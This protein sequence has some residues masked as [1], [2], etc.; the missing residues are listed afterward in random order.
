MATFFATKEELIQLVRWYRE[1]QLENKIYW[2]E[3]RTT[4]VPPVFK[5]SGS[6]IESS[7]LEGSL[8]GT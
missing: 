1:Q 3:F 8:T 7:L 2:Y 6:T 5:M 4:E